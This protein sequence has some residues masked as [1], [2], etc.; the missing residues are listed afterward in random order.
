MNNIGYMLGVFYRFWIILSFPLCLFVLFVF[1]LT[2]REKPQI[3]TVSPV[4]SISPDGTTALLESRNNSSAYKKVALNVADKVSQ[5]LF[6]FS[7][8]GQYA[9]NVANISKLIYENDPASRT[10]RE[11]I[12]RNFE[13][14]KT[15]TSTFT[16]D[17]KKTIAE[18]DPKDDR[19][20]VVLVE[21]YQTLSS[22]AGTTTNPVKVNLMMYFNDTRGEDGYVFKVSEISFN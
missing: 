16:L 22:T 13:Q 12:N 15:V 21:G 10:F 17:K 9:A 1:I 8:D 4:I 18:L 7:N 5:A 14:A 11:K 2:H 20:M 3:F 6:G 19:I